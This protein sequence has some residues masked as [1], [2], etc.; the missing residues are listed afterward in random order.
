ME[1]IS[2]APGVLAVRPVTTIYPALFVFYKQCVITANLPSRLVPADAANANVSNIVAAPQDNQSTH[3]MTVSPELCP[4]CEHNLTKIYPRVWTNFTLKE[5][6]E[7][8]SK[9]ECKFSIHYFSSYLLIENL[10]RIDTGEIYQGLIFLA[11][12]LTRVPIGVDYTHPSL[13]GGFGP[14][15]KVIGGYDFVGNAYDGS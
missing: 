13:G 10:L 6:Q 1:A 2:K 14:S 12:G 3:V 7:R 8:V 11:Q 15:F 9:L 4:L 5:L